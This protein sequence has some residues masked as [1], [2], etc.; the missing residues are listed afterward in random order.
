MGGKKIHEFIGLR[1]KV[2]SLKYNGDNAIEEKHRV[3]GINSNSSERIKHEEY[4][5]VFT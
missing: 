4:L 1:S 2:Y 5:N 3:K